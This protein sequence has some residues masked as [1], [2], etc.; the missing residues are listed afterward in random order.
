MEF[1]S[2]C[3]VGA[4][5]VGSALAARLAERI[6]AW[7]TG[8]ELETGDA[9]LVLLCVP[10]RAVSETAATI[11]PGPWIAHTSGV[12]TLDALAP[13]SRRFSLHPLQAFVRERG[14]EQIDGAW[15]AVSAETD[16]ALSAGFALAELLGLRAFELEDAERPL[17][18]AAAA[19]ASSFLATLHWAASELFHEVGAPPEALVPLMRRTMENG[20]ELTGPLTR[21]DWG[22]VERHLEVVR[23]RRPDLEPMYRA[24]VDV[25]ATVAA[26]R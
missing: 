17:Y 11:P 7:T 23:E 3:V 25:A 20:F 18:H 2:A 6:P 1:T 13:H 12:R 22:T 8:R 15:A 26:A 19:V 24:L 14:P 5:R 4:G 10:D 9:D 16:A 21:G